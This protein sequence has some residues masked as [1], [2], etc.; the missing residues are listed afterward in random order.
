[1]EIKIGSKVQIKKVIG[2]E[3]LSAD[4]EFSGIIDSIN[5]SILTIN[6]NEMLCYVHSRYVIGV[7]N[8]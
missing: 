8:I 6:T 4:V 3:K 7:E 2:N 5:G 1:M